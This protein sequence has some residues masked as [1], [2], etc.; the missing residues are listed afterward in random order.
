MADAAANFTAPLRP[1]PEGPQGSLAQP[2]QQSPVSAEPLVVRGSIS[3][4]N[5]F[6]DERDC[7]HPSRN[8]SRSKLRDRK[9]DVVIFNYSVFPDLLN[10]EDGGGGKADGGGKAG[11]DSI[12]DG[13]GSG[14]GP[15]S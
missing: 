15:P 13:G 10:A 1:T 12:S 6:Y 2:P 14:G 7:L 8:L 3:R 5:N 9:E 4:R 11:C